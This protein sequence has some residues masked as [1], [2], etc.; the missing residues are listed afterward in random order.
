MSDASY[1]YHARQRTP[2][3]QPIAYLVVS[4][5]DLRGLQHLDLVARPDRAA[6]DYPRTDTTTTL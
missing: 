5:K 6:F 4:V 3:T 2:S 1:G